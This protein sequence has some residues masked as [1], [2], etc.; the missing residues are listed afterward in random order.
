MPTISRFYGI[1]IFLN[2]NDPDPPHF[3]ARYQDN[4]VTVTIDSFLVEGRMPGRALQL[5]IEW[6]RV[7]Q[8]E[9]VYNWARARSHEP[10][11]QI[12]PFVVGSDVGMFLHV[13]SAEMTGKYTLAINFSNGETREIDLVKEL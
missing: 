12:E 9:L 11:A 8:E 5:I 6:A 7:H 3:H 1:V 2:Y 13:V 10:L 4:E